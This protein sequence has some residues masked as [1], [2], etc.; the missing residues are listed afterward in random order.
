MKHIHHIIPKHMGGTDD[1]SN[2]I[3][4]TVAEHAQAHK[5]LYEQYGKTEDLCAYYMLSGKNQDPEFVKARASLGGKGLAKKRWANNEQ[6]GFAVMDKEQ[7]F[8]IQSTNGKL[9]GNRN[10]KSGHMTRIQKMSNPSEA[11]KKGGVTTM[12]RG[13]GSFAD[14]V[15]RLKSASKGG[16]TQGKSNAE[17]GHLKR[18][19]QMSIEQNPRSKGKQWITNGNEN[20][21][22]TK[23]DLIPEGYRAGKVQKK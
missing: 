2:L 14:P 11:G 1:P 19:A 17:T 21:M 20:M 6:W 5:E 13:K 15:E 7:L 10:A 16:K 23:G 3:E 4:L 18:I 9:Q 8:E 22:I 12:A